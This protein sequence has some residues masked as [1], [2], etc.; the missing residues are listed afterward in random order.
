MRNCRG[1]AVLLS[2]MVLTMSFAACSGGNHSENFMKAAESMMSFAA[3]SGGNHSD[4]A[5]YDWHATVRI[6]GE[7]VEGVLFQGYNGKEYTLARESIAENTKDFYFPV[8]AGEKT[9]TMDFA[10]APSCRFSYAFFLTGTGELPTCE[11]SIMGDFSEEGSRRTE[12]LTVPE[13]LKEGNEKLF[14]AISAVWDGEFQNGEYYISLD[15]I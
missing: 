11:E 7:I 8:S 1:L 9:L 6:D 3:C 15:L 10:D 2:G 13:S 4:S 14:L 12:T 5:G